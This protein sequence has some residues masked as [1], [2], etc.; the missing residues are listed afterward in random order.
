MA[1]FPLLVVWGQSALDH[2][3]AGFG[4][5]QSRCSTPTETSIDRK[6]VFLPW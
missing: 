5:I 4:V 1:I 2:G 6:S 3:E